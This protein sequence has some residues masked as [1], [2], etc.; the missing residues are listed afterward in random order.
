GWSAAA[1]S[2]ASGR[3]AI[4]ISEGKPPGRQAARGLDVGG[5]VTRAPP[6]LCWRL[7]GLAAFLSE[8]GAGTSPGRV[9]SR[10]ESERRWRLRGGGRG[11][12]RGLGGWRR[13]GWR[14]AGG[15]ARGRWFQWMRRSWPAGPVRWLPRRAGWCGQ[16][17]GW[18]R[19]RGGLR[20]DRER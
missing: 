1:W 20:G 8:M 4:E 2:R 18:P 19:R 17:E 15:G 14:G 16:R 9:P 3:E 6:I 11:R 13:R 5:R 12:R 10:A 7:G